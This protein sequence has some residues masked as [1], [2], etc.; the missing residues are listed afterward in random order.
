V[1][2]GDSFLE[3][4]PSVAPFGHHPAYGGTVPASVAGLWS[5]IACYD[6]PM[7]QPRMWNA[8]AIVMIAG[9]IPWFAAELSAQDPSWHTLTSQVLE[10]CR[11][12]HYDD[13]A[14]LASDALALARRTS[15][16]DPF[17]LIA[18]LSNLGEI[19][20]AQAS[21]DEAEADLLEALRVIRDRDVPPDDP[22]V[23]VVLSHLAAVYRAQGRDEEAAVL[24]ARAQELA[25]PPP[26]EQ[27]LLPPA[28]DGAP[29]RDTADAETLERRLFSQEQALGERH[30]TVART[31]RDL[32]ARLHAE[33]APEDAVPL[34]ER[35]ESIQSEQLGRSHPERAGTARRLADACAASGR[36]EEAL[37]WYRDA[38]AALT[39]GDR[40]AGADH[41]D[42][43]QILTAMSGL[44][45]LAGESQPSRAAIERALAILSS[46]I[47]PHEAR[48]QVL[49]RLLSLGLPQP[50]S[51][52]LLRRLLPYP[53]SG[54]A[55]AGEP[56]GTAGDP[57]FQRF[58]EV[59]ELAAASLNR[60]G[61]LAGKPS[62]EILLAL[63][64]E[65][66]RLYEGLVGPDHPEL[67]LLLGAYADALRQSGDAARTEAVERRIERLR[68]QDR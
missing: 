36:L 24:E 56:A 12:R 33:G 13:A 46:R 27:R 10:A 37:A 52:P 30:P 5:L 43:A 64:E 57:R 53:S 20:R 60:T 58:H 3:S 38:L 21:Y 42:A 65:A 2:F 29:D 26:D 51:R 50:P 31:L 32:G 40:A 19:R 15:A 25:P 35:A 14:R 41:P 61:R 49:A 59:M 4:E 17:P 54:E 6:E 16:H 28:Q 47:G 1:S 18:S 62:Q 8:I 55:G 7:R 45:D 67:L 34:L 11:Q 44:H 23:G 63:Y 9:L 66:L 48:Q 39:V 68:T 22:A